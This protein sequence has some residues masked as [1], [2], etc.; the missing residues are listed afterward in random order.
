M[1]QRSQKPSTLMAA[2]HDSQ[3]IEAGLMW[4]PWASRNSNNDSDSILIDAIC[5]TLQSAHHPPF[6]FVAAQVQSPS[7]GDGV[8]S[9]S[10]DTMDRIAV[11]ITCYAPAVQGACVVHKRRLISA[12]H[13][14]TVVRGWMLYCDRSAEEA[15]K[16]KITQRGNGKKSGKAGKLVTVPNALR[17]FSIAHRRA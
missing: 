15:K 12:P 2:M 3:R 9:A 16:R 13:D 4:C 6:I 7:T 14:D 10:S 8:A 5:P 1:P 11:R 17:I